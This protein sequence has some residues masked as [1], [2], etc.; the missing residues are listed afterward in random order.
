MLHF[1]AQFLIQIFMKVLQNQTRGS[2]RRS[3]PTSSSGVHSSYR[4]HR[5]VFL[6]A[7]G[8]AR[9]RKRVGSSQNTSVHLFT[10]RGLLHAIHFIQYS[11][12]PCI[13]E[14]PTSTGVRRTDGGEAGN[15]KCFSQKQP[16][17]RSHT[18][19]TG[20]SFTLKLCIFRSS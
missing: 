14:S 17:V 5:R 20:R 7:Q 13:F 10:L 11:E 4:V 18:E 8:A 2:H 1:I 6:R 3:M 19:T 15:K 16:S 9:L 12:S